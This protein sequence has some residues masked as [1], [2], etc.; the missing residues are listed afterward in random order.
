MEVCVVD[1]VEELKEFV[2]MKK[3]HLHAG[4][5]LRQLKVLDV[6]RLR[7]N[8]ENM[9]VLVP[10]LKEM[11][12]LEV[13][14]FGDQYPENMLI[15]RR[16]IAMKKKD[17]KEVAISLDLLKKYNNALTMNNRLSDTGVALLTSVLPSLVSLRVLDLSSNMIGWNGAEILSKVMGESNLLNLEQFYLSG[18]NIGKAGTLA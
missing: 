7:W 12:K 8:A 16:D 5:R 2:G 14:I 6:S 3:L 10:V 18:N 11:T 9:K 4:D 15:E 17:G 13:L 1:S